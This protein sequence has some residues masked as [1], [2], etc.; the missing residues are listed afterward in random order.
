VGL[1]L[2]P[3]HHTGRIVRVVRNNSPKVNGDQEDPISDGQILTLHKQADSLEE[4][5]EEEEEEE[6][7]GGGGGEEE[8]EVSPTYNWGFHRDISSHPF[9]V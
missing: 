6:G 3:G 2:F 5:E 9:L 8:G 7:G 4:E 1:F